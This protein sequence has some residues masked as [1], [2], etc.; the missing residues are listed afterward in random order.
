MQ[1]SIFNVH[2]EIEYLR[3]DG[4]G[5]AIDRA[6]FETPAAFNRWFHNAYPDAERNPEHINEWYSEAENCIIYA[7][8]DEY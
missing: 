1:K 3:E 2:V 6:T 8:E 7:Y 4:I 5:Y